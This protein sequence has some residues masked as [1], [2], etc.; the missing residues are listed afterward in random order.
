MDVKHLPTDLYVQFADLLHGSKHIT[1]ILPY[2]INHAKKVIKTTD[3]F[4]KLDSQ[5]M[6]CRQLKTRKTTKLSC[7]PNVVT[8]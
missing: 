7:L 2:F 5:A 6:K 4:C 3:R 8:K 1:D